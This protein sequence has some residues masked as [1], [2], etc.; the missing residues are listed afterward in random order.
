MIEQIRTFNTSV[1]ENGQ[2]HMGENRAFRCTKCELIVLLKQELANHQ[3][4]PK[5]K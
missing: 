1:R 4:K 5:H 2:T 3:C